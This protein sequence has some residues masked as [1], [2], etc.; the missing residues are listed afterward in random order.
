MVYEI[1]KKRLGGKIFQIPG[2]NAPL[3]YIVFHRDR[4]KL[5]ECLKAQGIGAVWQYRTLSEHPPYA[6][7]AQG[8]YPNADFWT[9]YAVYLPFGLALEPEDAERMAE[10]V[11]ASGVSL[12]EA[13]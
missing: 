5:L 1:L 11:L 9:Q 6:H 2:E 3:H 8:K 12:L 13:A 10:A 7:L 4:G